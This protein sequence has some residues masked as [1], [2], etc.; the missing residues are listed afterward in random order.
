MFSHCRKLYT[1]STL[2][3]RKG[4]LHL[5]VPSRAWSYTALLENKGEFDLGKEMKMLFVIVNR[6]IL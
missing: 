3:K 1:Q 6:N 2:C 5:F 4:K